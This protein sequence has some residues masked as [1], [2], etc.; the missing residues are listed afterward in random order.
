MANLTF[1]SEFD[2]TNDTCPMNLQW[3]QTIIDN[4]R[5]SL[6]VCIIATIIHTIFWSQFIFCPSVRQK[7]M[8]WIYAYLV[9]NILLLLQFF[10]LFIVHTSST[11]CMPNRV[12]YLF[13]CYL[14]ATL[15]N[16]LN[17]LEVYIL[18]ALNV[19]RYI[20]IV[21]NRSVYIHHVRLLVCAHIVIYIIPLLTFI[22]QLSINWAVL[23][24]HRGASC[25]IEFTNIYAQ[26]VNVIVGFVL[27]ILLNICIIYRNM[28]HVHLT[29]GLNQTQHHVT[30][31]EKYH[32]SLVIQFL[33]FYTIWI[34]LWSPNVITYQFTSGTS[35]IT[36]LTSLLNYIEIA[37]DPIII[38]ALDVRFQHVWRK[39]WVYI[40]AITLCKDPSQRRVVPGITTQNRWTG[41][42]RSTTPSNTRRSD[43]QFPIQI[44]THTT[45]NNRL[46]VLPIPI[47]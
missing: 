32:R 37:L 44:H 11:E 35:K 36:L 8:Q 17:I 33:V 22:I 12:W 4:Q 14:E 7:S 20:Q 39:L 10:F 45:E 2:N 27:P 41:Y 29:S 26:I 5:S 46:A 19:C 9:T 43:H 15:D 16:Y 38:A 42:G 13:V 40:R 47:A 34:L 1:L 3:T 24:E 23:R 31:R 18:F 25:D 6:Y 21:H 28:H 30:A